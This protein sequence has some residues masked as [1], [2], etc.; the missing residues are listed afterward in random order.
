VSA[1]LLLD[2]SSLLSPLFF[3]P[4]PLPSLSLLCSSSLTSLPPGSY[5]RQLR[6]EEWKGKQGTSE[7]RG[8]EGG[9]KEEEEQEVEAFWRFRF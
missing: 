1:H 6:R 3:L 5:A 7:G 8:K 9:K 4:L 2:F